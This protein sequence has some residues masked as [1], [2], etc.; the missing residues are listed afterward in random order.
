MRRLYR[1]LLLLHP[2]PFRDAFAEE[3]LWIYDQAGSR[4]LL[5]DVVLSLIRQRLFRSGTWK[6]PVAL[7]GGLLQVS[8]GGLGWLAM[9]SPQLESFTAIQQFQGGWSGQAVLDRRPAPIELQLEHSGSLWTG[10]LS[11][12]GQALSLEEVTVQPGRVDFSVD[13]GTALLRFRGKRAPR[14][15]AISGVLLGPPDGTF[16][17]TRE[18]PCSNCA[19]SANDIA[20]SR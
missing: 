2:Q 14:G 8:L 15:G 12:L 6:I 17:L 10:H 13:V 11:Y 5:G 16:K 9:S 3:M 19:K 18:D 20:A 7:A 1:L 4:A